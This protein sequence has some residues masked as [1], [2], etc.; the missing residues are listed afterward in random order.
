MFIFPVRLLTPATVRRNIGKSTLL[1]GETLSG[2]QDVT[3]TDGGGRW[4]IEY[5]GIELVTAQQT[6]V[7]EAWLDYLAEGATVC[8]VPLLSFAT[9][10]RAMPSDRPKLP[11]R[12]FVDDDEWP[13]QMRFGLPEHEAQFSAGAL[14]RATTV[15]LDV[16][17]GPEPKGGE[18]FS[19]GERAY[20]LQRPNGDG[21]Y[22]V[23]PPL[24]E[25]VAL[26]TPA[27][28][29]FPMVRARLAPAQDFSGPLAR[30]VYGTVGLRFVEA[31][32][33]AA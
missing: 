9:S 30:G 17:K 6:R 8:L 16:T 29:D 20:R 10:P 23:R 22:S 14:L 31:T 27:V 12:L 32:G 1:G 28:F 11:S 21:T 2:D 26:G 5:A 4:E 24:R 3:T 33:N 18:I 13:T 19:A 25:A 15:A 7:W